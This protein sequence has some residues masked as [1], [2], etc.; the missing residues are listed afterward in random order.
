MVDAEVAKGATYE[1]LAKAFGMSTPYSLETGWRYNY[2]RKP[3]LDTV[4]LMA[5]YFKLPPDRLFS[6]QG[7][8]KSAGALA[9][10]FCWKVLEGDSAALLT[11]E[12][13]ITIQR[14]AI[15]KARQVANALLS[16]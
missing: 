3:H 6:P 5:E 14:A 1:D 13:A 8:V 12:Q 15:A 10:E 2:D 9:R 7:M 4:E 16:D 11:D